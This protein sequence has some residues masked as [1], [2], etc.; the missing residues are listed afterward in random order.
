MPCNTVDRS[1]AWNCVDSV[2]GQ[3]C[4]NCKMSLQTGILCE[5]TSFMKQKNSTFLDGLLKNEK[6]PSKNGTKIEKEKLPSKKVG[7]LGYAGPHQEWHQPHNSSPS[8]RSSSWKPKPTE[9]IRAI[10]ART[11]YQG[12][13]RTVL[14]C[15]L[16]NL[17]PNHLFCILRTAKAWHFEFHVFQK[18]RSPCSR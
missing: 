8:S 14:P 2:C 12:Y 11:S 5:I 15:L 1:Q 3:C 18:G 17:V 16:V 7:Q 6:L 10:R 13:I 9:K 4:L